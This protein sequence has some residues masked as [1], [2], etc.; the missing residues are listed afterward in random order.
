MVFLVVLL[1][2]LSSPCGARG[3][4]VLA[5]ADAVVAV[6]NSKLG[7]LWLVIHLE[8]GLP[9]AVSNAQ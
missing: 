7:W 9:G 4:P 6:A 5:V 1:S 3:C 8:P 2:S